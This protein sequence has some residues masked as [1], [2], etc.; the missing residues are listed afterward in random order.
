VDYTGFLK[1]A[2]GGQ[3]PPLAVLHGPEPFLLEDA[4]ARVTHALFGDATD[5]SLCREVLDARDAGAAGIVQAAL[6]LPWTG[7]RRLVVARGV[8]ELPAKGA[9]ALGAYCQSPNP[10]TVLLLLADQPLAATHWL[11]K[12]VPRGAIV[13]V[14]VPAG[15]QLVAWLRGRAQ[16]DAIE[17]AEDA[18]RLLV[19]LVGDDLARLHGEMEKAALAGG[20]DHRR[21][22]VEQIRAVVGETRARHV[23]ELTRAIVA[24]DVGAALALL[25]ALLAA[26]EDPFALLGMLAREARTAWRAAEGLRLGRPEPDIARSLGRPPGAAAAMID[27]A[28]VLGPGAAARMLERCWQAERRLKLGG[29][30]RAELSLLVADLCA[31]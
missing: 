8:D 29:T 22:G 20:P 2:D 25:N 23:F 16:A 30:P 17:L 15:G 21:V 18:A 4:V 14:P 5:L 13:A 28:R 27:R 10:S 11:Q 7:P 12:A 3:P 31:G 24:R 9:E 26:G 1:A 19:E 6:T